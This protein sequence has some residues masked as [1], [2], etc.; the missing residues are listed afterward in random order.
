MRETERETIDQA[1]PVDTEEEDVMPPEDAAEDPLFHCAVCGQHP[2]HN[3]FF[4]ICHACR[5]RI[6]AQVWNNTTEI[7]E[8]M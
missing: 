8:G 3:V 1:I 2:T 6:M 4:V 5:T 7:T